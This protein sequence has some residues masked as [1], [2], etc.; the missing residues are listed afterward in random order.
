[1]APDDYRKTCDDL[2]HQIWLRLE[3]RDEEKLRFATRGT[4]SRVLQDDQLRRFMRSLDLRPPPLTEAHFAERVKD[5]DLH[6]FLATIIFAACSAEAAGTFVTKLAAAPDWPVWNRFGEEVGRLPANRAQLNEFFGNAVDADKFL[7]KQAYFATVVLRKREEVC[8]K[9]GDLQRLPYLQ[10]TYV[11]EGSFGKVYKVVIATGHFHDARSRTGFH[12]N[13]GPMELARK[14]YD[15]ALDEFRAKVEY[16]VMMKILNSQTPTCDNIVESLGYL[17]IGSSYSLFMPLAIC[18]LREYIMVNHRAK[19]QT[20]EA[21][22]DIIRCAAGLAAG[23][24]FLHEGIVTRDFER[25]VCY[26]MDLNPSNILIFHEYDGYQQQKVWKLSDFGMSRVKVRRDFNGS[27]AQ[28]RDF[29]NLFTRRDRIRDPSVSATLNK[30]AEGTYLAPESISAT[31]SMQASSDVWSLGC[32]TSV[33]FTYLEEGSDGVELYQ[34]ARGQHHNAD[35]LDRFFLRGTRFT[36]S[37]VHPSIKSWHT[38]LIDK[39]TTRDPKE[40]EAVAYV[41]RKLETDVLKVDGKRR[42]SSKSVKEMLEKAYKMYRALSEVPA[43]ADHKPAT[44]PYSLANIFRSRVESSPGTGVS[45]WH[46]L[47]LED[48]KGSVISPDAA[49]VVYWTDTKI[50]LYTSQSLMHLSG[51]KLTPSAEFTLPE[52]GCFWK[53]MCLSRRH[54]IAYTT[55]CNN[56]YLFSLDGGTAVDANLAQWE[57]KVLQLPE[58]HR[59]AVSPDGSKL[60]C[61]AQ[62]EKGGREPGSLFYAAMSD[63]FRA[64]QDREPQPNRGWKRLALKWLAADVVHLSVSDA[65]D[66]DLVIRPE[67]T[68]RSPEH[69]IPIMHVSLKAATIDTLN[70]KSGGYDSSSTRSFFTAFCPY[71][72]EATC[73]VVTHEKRLHIQKFSGTDSSREVQKDIPNYRVRRL[74]IGHDG[75]LFALGTTAASYRMLLLEIRVPNQE[76]ELVVRQLGQLPGLSYSDDFCEML[77]DG[78]DEKCILVAA[79]TRTIYRVAIP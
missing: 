16:Q 45:A 41:L 4:S 72:H 19:P 42:C 21:K 31:R 49:H 71:W 37:Q 55:G 15:I 29:S 32:V 13:T 5:R 43:S 51:A 38:K 14:D 2:Y 22:A 76:S 28:E 56:C 18:D 7:T 73:A 57:K 24:Q 34:D 39:A 78:Q 27:N 47:P 11:G 12:F 54:L 50:M 58:V 40:G 30:R 61:V 46:V 3:R 10:E 70:I 69:K 75:R 66:V 6:D 26:H 67:R 8:V 36:E 17:Q 9:D 35:D 62:N 53:S 74:L 63:L 59:L 77:S 1:M 52:Q 64:G 33:L 23:L 48:F 79:L 44:P 25:L 60:V 65:N 20:R 68:T